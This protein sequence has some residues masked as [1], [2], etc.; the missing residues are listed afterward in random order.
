LIGVWQLLQSALP[1]LAS[2]VRHILII[3]F[4]QVKARGVVP[5]L[6]RLDPVGLRDVRYLW[7]LETVLSSALRELIVVQTGVSVGELQLPLVLRMLDVPVHL[8]VDQLLVRVDQF[9]AGIG[10][11]HRQLLY[12]VEVLLKRECIA[13]RVRV[14]LAAVVQLQFAALAVEVQTLSDQVAF[15]GV[16][17]FVVFVRQL[18]ES[19]QRASDLSRVELASLRWVLDLGHF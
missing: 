4:A 7:Q 17:V 14:L 10:V 2:V 13:D 3:L 1:L 6:P 16:L 11:Y 18:V 8:E 9:V 5:L 15:F 19:L 12:L